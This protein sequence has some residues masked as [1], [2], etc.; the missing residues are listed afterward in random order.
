MLNDL[1]ILIN[2]KVAQFRNESPAA[3]SSLVLDEFISQRAIKN[4]Y[5]KNTLSTIIPYWV[6]KAQAEGSILIGSLVE[7]KRRQTRRDL[8]Q[9]NAG[10]YRT[11]QAT[12]RERDNLSKQTSYLNQRILIFGMITGA[13]LML[14]LL[15]I[16]VF[17]LTDFVNSHLT[18]I[19]LLIGFIIGAMFGAPSH[20]LYQN[21]QMLRKYGQELNDISECEALINDIFNTDANLRHLEGGHRGSFFSNN[22]NNRKPLPVSY[23]VVRAA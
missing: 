13:L 9:I 22:S 23:Q 18:T 19:L 14:S 20:I 15:S 16:C 5:V 7:T 11:K 10:I 4:S 2:D 17:N 21:T 8:N 3:L 1:K 12:T 6:L